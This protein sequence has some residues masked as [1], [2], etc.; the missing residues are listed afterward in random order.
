MALPMRTPQWHQRQRARAARAPHR[1]SNRQSS[2][3]APAHWCRLTWISPPAF[4]RR[5]SMLSSAMSFTITAQLQ[6]R[7]QARGT[8]GGRARTRQSAQVRQ[9]ATRR[10]ANQLALLPRSKVTSHASH[11]RPFLLRRMCCSSVDLP[12]PRKPDSRVTG[13]RRSLPPPRRALTGAGGGGGGGGV[14]PQICQFCKAGQPQWRRAHAVCRHLASP[15]P[16]GAAWRT[17]L[18]C[19]RAPGRRSSREPSSAGIKPPGRAGARVGFAALHAPA[20]RGRLAWPRRCH[21]Q[22]PEC[23][24][25]HAAVQAARGALLSEPASCFFGPTAGLFGAP[26]TVPPASLTL[27]T[28]SGGKGSVQAA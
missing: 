18:T 4:T 16:W 19:R 5:A 22:G 23:R 17:A 8:R 11:R 27:E 28:M 14:K 9:L 2:E 15:P 13:R 6:Q 25:V 1:T 20:W 7:R 10:A 24:Q 3:S 21:P 26:N 12:A